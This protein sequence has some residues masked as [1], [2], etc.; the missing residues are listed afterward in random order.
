MRRRR[1]RSGGILWDAF[2]IAIVCVGG[3]WAWRTRDRW[4]K[5]LNRVP[6]VAGWLKL[7]KP[8]KPPAIHLDRQSALA[9]TQTREFLV[10]AGVGEKDLL[11][12]YNEERREGGIA[13]IESTLEISRPKSFQTGPFLKRVLAFLSDSNLSLM[14]DDTH[15]GTWILEF[16]DRTHVFQRLV[17]HGG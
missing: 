5:H 11:K 4:I 7:G 15:R 13:W 8:D 9:Q 3:F 12:C 2:L 16:G 17:I 10:K 1:H 14:R 6:R